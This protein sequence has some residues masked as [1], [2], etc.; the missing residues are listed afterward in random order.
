MVLVTFQFAPQ[1]LPFASFVR[2]QALHMDLL[3]HDLKLHVQVTKGRSEGIFRHAIS[4]QHLHLSRTNAL[5]ILVTVVLGI[6]GGGAVSRLSYSATVSQRHDQKPACELDP[7]PL[8]P[9]HL[10][11]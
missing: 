1:A 6:G 10:P 5:R 4:T 2:G 11:F 3:I 8:D 7:T 9:L